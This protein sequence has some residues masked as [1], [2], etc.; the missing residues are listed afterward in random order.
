MPIVPSDL[1]FKVSNT[2]HK[3]VLGLSGNRI[4]TTMMNMPVLELSTVGR[5]S[6]RRHSV[7]LAAAY[8]EGDTIVV[9]ASRGGDDHHPA[10]FLNVR[11]NPD[12]TVGIGGGD[13]KPM[14]AHVANPEDR[15]RL[16]P[17]VTA[18]HK[19]YAD[20]QKR[21]SREIPVVVLEPAG[22]KS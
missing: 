20:Y 5:K 11:D 6:G 9:I 17:L 13:A 1:F 7:L 14:R 8:V 21:T 2:L 19:N 15:A 10:W 3:A 4:G 12:V 18:E 16:W 22:P